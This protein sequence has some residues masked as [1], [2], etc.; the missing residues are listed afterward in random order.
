MRVLSKVFKVL[1]VVVVALSVVGLWKQAEVKRLLAVNSLFDAD[2]ITQNFSHMDALFLNRGLAPAPDQT[3][4]ANPSPLP[5][6][7]PYAL[8][9]AVL[10]WTADRAVTGLVILKNGQLVHESYY[11][12]TSPDDL[13]ISWSMAKSVLSALLG[14]VV[15]EGKITSL[16]D[17]VVKYVPA[18]TGSAYD[19]ATIRNVLNMSSGVAF[20]E[21]YLDFWSDINQM[22]RV[23]ALGGSMDAFAA[24][25]HTRAFEPGSQWHYCSIDTHVIGMVIRGATGQSIAD[26]MQSRIIAPM[27]LESAP[28]YLTDG[29][30]EP[31][32]LGGLNLRT[33]DYA[34][35]GQMIAQGGVWQGRQ[36]VPADWVAASIKRSAP[37]GAGYGY[38]W[39]VPD[40]A[41]PGEVMAQGIYGQYIYINQRLDVVI[42]V[43]A[44]DRGFEDAGVDQTNLALFR[45]IAAGL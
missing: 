39:W 13:R 31:F 15:A 7:P 17:Q 34:R 23:L 18:L 2:R 45:T 16:D 5:P 28:Y 9:P 11:L 26:L 42:A 4:A 35:I 32:V 36:I 27:G 12:G 1:L 8:P 10:Q 14:T 3:A 43:N 37:G 30:G 25:R 24:G 38:Q 44:A 33:R 29:L 22:G 19:G 41:E 21:D 40:D 20:N 6:G